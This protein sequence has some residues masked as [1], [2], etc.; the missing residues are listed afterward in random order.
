L[1]EEEVQKIR[2]E[3][4]AVLVD[5]AKAGKLEEWREPASK[6]TRGLI[7]TAGNAVSR[8]SPLPRVCR[9]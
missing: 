2:S 6:G 4:C 7:W 9:G 1:G 8:H 3:L 5:A